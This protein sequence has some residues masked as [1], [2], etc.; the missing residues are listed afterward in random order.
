MI[1]QKKV[2]C[3]TQAPEIQAQVIYDGKDETR[4]GCWMQKHIS[5]DCCSRV[6][7]HVTCVNDGKVWGFRL[8]Y[9]MFPLGNFRPLGGEKIVYKTQRRI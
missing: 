5:L 3:F 9:F 2:V 4:Y 7:C 8:S 6:L 1:T